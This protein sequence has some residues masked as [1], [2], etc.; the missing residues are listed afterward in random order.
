MYHRCIIDDGALRF[1]VAYTFIN[2]VAFTKISRQIEVMKNPRWKQRP[3][4]HEKYST[5]SVHHT[6]INGRHIYH[7]PS[8]A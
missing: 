7:S 2:V 8:L 1:A 6:L 4:H 5:V 3:I